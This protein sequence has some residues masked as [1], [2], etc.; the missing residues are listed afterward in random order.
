M[1]HFN[2]SFNIIVDEYLPPHLKL[3]LCAS[4]AAICLMHL[5]VNVREETQQAVIHHR[6]EESGS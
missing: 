4:N 2:W 5:K 6:G 3:V 1:Y